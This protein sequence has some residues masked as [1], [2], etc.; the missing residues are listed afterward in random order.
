[1]RDERGALPWV[2][3]ATC[4]GSAA[5]A[6]GPTFVTIWYSAPRIR[7]FVVS[8]A[9]VSSPI[10]TTPI[11]SNDCWSRITDSA[12]VVGWISHGNAGARV[13]GAAV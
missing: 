8:A 6:R 2:T 7:C 11:F 3:V 5:A 9:R 10:W 4:S 13:A 12:G 1:M